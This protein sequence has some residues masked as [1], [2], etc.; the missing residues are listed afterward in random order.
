VAALEVDATP[1]APVIASPLFGLPVRGQVEVRGTAADPRFAVYRV[2]AR[3]AGAPSWDPPLATSSTQA[4]NAALA[5]WDTSS[6]PDGDYDLRLSVSDSLGLVGIAQVTVIVDNHA[7]FADVT[8]PARV[9]AASGGDVFT[10]NREAHLYFPP[11]AFSRDAIVTIA[12]LPDADVPD[13]LSP[14]AVRVRSG[15]ELSWS[16]AALQKPVRLE[17]SYAGAPLPGGNL[18]VYVS[19]AGTAWRRLGGTLERDAQSLTL[20]LTE[21]GRY[22]LFADSGVRSERGGLSGISFTPRVFSP[23][24][25][26]ADREVGIGFTLGRPAPVTIR[27]YARNGRLIRDVLVDAPMGAGANLVRWDGT[28]RDGGFVPNGIYMVAVQAL[29]E[30]R[31]GALAVVR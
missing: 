16:G 18:A 3:P 21:P 17:L 6:L 20:A 14:G 29:G 4:A 13:T 23:T 31:Q 25:T 11:H 28:D 1:P 12:P 2:E 30:T 7:P 24:G 5:T 10:T 26:F 15:Y 27:V 9:S 19:S 22:A 8:T